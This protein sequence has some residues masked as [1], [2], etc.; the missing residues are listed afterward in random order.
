MS[1][2]SA[3]VSDTCELIA[4]S[5]AG[6][7]F[8]VDVHAVREIRSYTAATPMPHAP[9]YVCCVVNLR[10]TVLPIVDLGDRLGL[11]R[12]VPNARSAIIVADLDGGL[13]GQLVDAMSSIMTARNDQLQPAPDVASALARSCV[14]AVLA[15]DDR[16]IS[17]LSLQDILAQG[18]DL[19]A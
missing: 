13:V 10:G 17:L 14:T 4:F 15:I 5:A 3:A 16:M 9:P 1:E 6:Q 18:A 19:A 11:G 2:V 8:C 7:E 12:T